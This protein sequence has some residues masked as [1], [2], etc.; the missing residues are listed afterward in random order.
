MN[1]VAGNEIPAGALSNH[2][3]DNTIIYVCEQA[4]Q[5]RRREAEQE[6]NWRCKERESTMKSTP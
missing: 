6:R 2:L 4:G 1:R 3:H 5:A